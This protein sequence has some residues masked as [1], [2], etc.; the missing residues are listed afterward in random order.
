MDYTPNQR[1]FGLDYLFLQRKTQEINSYNSYNG[2]NS[3]NSLL[4][5]I[6]IS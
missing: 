6:G 1:Y 5:H 2:R 3:H 4:I